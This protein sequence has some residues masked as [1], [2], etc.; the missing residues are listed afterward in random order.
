MK[1]DLGQGFTHPFDLR[2]L[3][4][5]Y[6]LRVTDDSQPTWLPHISR[7]DFIQ[8]V[9]TAPGYS[10]FCTAFSQL[11][12]GT[13]VVVLPYWVWLVLDREDA[14]AQ[15]FTPRPEQIGHMVWPPVFFSKGLRFQDR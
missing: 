11:P 8:N 14:Q 6:H 7:K 13:E 2:S 9:P 4:A 10:S 5:G 12:P 15:T 1:N 3:Q